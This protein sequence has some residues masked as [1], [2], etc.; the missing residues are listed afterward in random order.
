MRFYKFDGN[1]TLVGIAEDIVA[2]KHSV[3]D[4]VRVQFVRRV[5]RRRKSLIRR[6]GKDAQRIAAQIALTEMLGKNRARAL[7]GFRNSG[8]RFVRL[9]G[10]GEQRP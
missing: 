8:G 3:I 5:L 4:G 1:L 7:R 6:R 9:L 10:T 2:F